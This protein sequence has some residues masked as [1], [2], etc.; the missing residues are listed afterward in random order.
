MPYR[1][2]TLRGEPLAATAT[3]RP[4]FGPGFIDTDLAAAATLE[5]WGSSFDD[6]GNDWCEYRLFD[7]Q[8]RQ[9]ACRR[10]DGY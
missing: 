1:I 10:L 4:P 8:G 9:I 3:R 6:P 5:L 2:D 7:A